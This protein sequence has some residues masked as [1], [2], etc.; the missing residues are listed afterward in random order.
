MA[1]ENSIGEVVEFGG[2]AHAVESELKPVRGF[3]LLFLCTPQAAALEW[4]RETL[5]AEVPCI[6]LTGALA[7]NPEVPLLI[8]DA[9]VDRDALCQP[10]ISAAQGL[11]LACYLALAPVSAAFG[12][13]R[14]VVTGMDSVSSVGRVGID[15]LQSEVVAL[16]NQEEMEEPIAFSRNIAFDCIPQLGPIDDD[17]EARR[18]REACALLARSFED[19]EFDVTS[20]QVPTFSGTGASLVVETEAD[21][22][23]LEAAECLAKSP[24]LELWT[25]GDG[26]ST[27]DPSGRDIVLVGRIR[28]LP[29]ERRG[30]RFWIAAD[31]LRLSATSAVRLAEARFATH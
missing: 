16:F 27:R 29:G 11:G 6:D 19:A 22:S 26:P 17:G 15:V 7:S 18:E 1:T 24:A 3:D 4:V 28:S 9:A 23:P 14:A 13:R 2:E 12:L 25:Q 5:R 30:L 31:P 8:P 10:V 21:V 20:V